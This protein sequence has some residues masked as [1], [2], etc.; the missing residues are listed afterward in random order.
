MQKKGITKIA[1][2]QPRHMGGC[3]TAQKVTIRK[4][5]I[6][7][8]D[9]FA[10]KKYIHRIA[11]E[12]ADYSSY[13]EKDSGQETKG[14]WENITSLS[15]VFAEK[16]GYDKE[17]QK[18]HSGRYDDWCKNKGVHVD[19]ESRKVMSEFFGIKTDRNMLKYINARMYDYRARKEKQRADARKAEMEMHFEGVPEIPESFMDSLEAIKPNNNVI[20]YHRS[21]T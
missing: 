21:K 2:V 16:S 4:R 5:D 6:L 7:I 9:L 13:P 8:I 3:I 1:P 15:G 19:H 11:F 17:T 20:Y 12:G 18:Y 14:E 10:D